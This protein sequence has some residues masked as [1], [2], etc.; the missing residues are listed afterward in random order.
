MPSTLQPAEV[1]KLS[2]ELGPHLGKVARVMAQFSKDPS[3]LTGA[4]WR[5]LREAAGLTRIQLARKTRTSPFKLWELE[6]EIEPAEPPEL[7]TA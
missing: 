2:N 7:V 1:T 3:K 4:E 5:K 6:A